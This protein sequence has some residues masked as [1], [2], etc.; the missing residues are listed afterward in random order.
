MGVMRTAVLLS[1]SPEEQAQDH[2]L[3]E[4]D[5]DEHDERREVEPAGLPRRQEP[6]DRGEHRLGRPGGGTARSGLRGSGL[7]QVMSAAAMIT[8]E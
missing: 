8:Q 6:A 2:P 4:L 1:A 7:T 5:G 3:D